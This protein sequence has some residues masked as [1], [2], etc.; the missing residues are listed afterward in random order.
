MYFKQLLIGGFDN[1]FSY[2]L[3]DEKSREVFVVDPDNW[4]MIRAVLEEDRLT[5]KGVLLTH[6]HFD[7]AGIAGR[8]ARELKVP[9]YLHFADKIHLREEIPNL[10]DLGTLNELMIGSLKIQVMHTPGHSPGAVCFLAENK[11]ITGDTVF[12]GRCGRTDLKGSD[13]AALMASIDK[14]KEL[15][16][17]TEIYAGHD[18]GETPSSTVGREKINNPFFG[19]F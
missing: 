3:G 18:Y 11:L 13:R 9:V 7:H 5:V 16:E 8:L 1:N 10:I 12:V 19:Q 14:I 6:G 15:P 4:E 17:E 2:I